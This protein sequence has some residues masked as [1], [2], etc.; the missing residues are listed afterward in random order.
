MRSPANLGYHSRVDETQR[1]LLAVFYA[2]DE[3][4]HALAGLVLNNVAAVWG[5]CIGWPG[6]LLNTFITSEIGA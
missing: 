2:L 4:T 6:E 5:G 1:R 3:V